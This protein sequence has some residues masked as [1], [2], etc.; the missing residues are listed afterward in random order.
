MVQ[1]FQYTK[2]FFFI[3]VQ[4]IL[5]FFSKNGVLRSEK[6]ATNFS[7]AVKYVVCF[8]AIQCTF[9][10]L[11]SLPK[12]SSMTSKKSSAKSKLV[13]IRSILFLNVRKAAEKLIGESLRSKTLAPVKISF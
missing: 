10:G 5:S 8:W 1:P 3:K 11:Q 13:A 12:C 4:R 2:M 7:G 6:D 9:V